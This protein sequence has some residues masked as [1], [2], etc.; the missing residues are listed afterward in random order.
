MNMSRSRVHPVTPDGYG[1]NADYRE[2]SYASR[3]YGSNPMYFS[4]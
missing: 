2:G 3:F 4:K 1:T